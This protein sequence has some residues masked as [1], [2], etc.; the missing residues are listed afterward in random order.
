MKIFILKLYIL[1][2]KK[3]G[4]STYVVTLNPHKHPNHYGVHK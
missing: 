2:Q 4:W 1:G 3:K